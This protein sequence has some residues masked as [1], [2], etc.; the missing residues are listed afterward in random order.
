MP[1]LHLPRCELLG[2]RSPLL[3]APMAGGPTM[4]ELVA[5]VSEVGGFGV[6]AAGRL[7][8]D[9]RAVSDQG[10]RDVIRAFVEQAVAVLERLGRLH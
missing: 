9:A 6:T 2:C 5:A 1:A 10:A 8:T 3:Q 7:T 4:P